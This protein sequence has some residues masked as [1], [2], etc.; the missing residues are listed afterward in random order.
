[1]IRLFVALHPP[2]TVRT[3]LLALMGGIAGARWQSDAQLHLTLAFLGEVD[4]DMAM[5]VDAALGAIDSAAIDVSLSGIGTFGT[6]DRPKA[7]W[8]GAQPSDALA[9]LAAKVEQACR[10]A[11]APLE[12]RA[13]VP[14]VTL[15]RLNR[16]SGPIMPF[17]AAHGDYRAPPWRAEG[18]A[19]TESRLGAGGSSY[20]AL[21][22]YPLR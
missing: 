9:A 8:I 10:R 6:P 21:R 1:M 18:F 12:R 7:L 2:A 16:S 13:F 22:D 15:A 4:E 17:L 14:H 19:L 11:G 3:A 20:T 5:R